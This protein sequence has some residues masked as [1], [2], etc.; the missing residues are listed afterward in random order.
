MLPG[1]K[2]YNIRQNLLR[3]KIIIRGKY[4]FLDVSPNNIKQGVSKGGGRLCSFERRFMA[5][6]RKSM[7]MSGSSV[8][9]GV[10]ALPAEDS[11]F[12]QGV[13]DGQKNKPHGSFWSSHLNPLFFFR[14]LCRGES[15]ITFLP[16]TH[17]QHRS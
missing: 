5:R 12:H 9:S 2:S 4:L 16:P 1:T 13:G 14:L 7:E 15:C 11:L 17:P 6:V 10:V 3:H 8:L